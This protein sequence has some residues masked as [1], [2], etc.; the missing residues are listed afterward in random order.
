MKRALCVRFGLASLVLLSVALAGCS[1]VDVGAGGASA[2]P[3]ALCTGSGENPVS[4]ASCVTYSQDQRH[5]DNTRY[6]D[7]QPVSPSVQAQLDKF[8]APARIALEALAHTASSADVVG[9]FESAGWDRR[10]VQTEDSEGG[11][12]TFGADA[13]IGCLVGAVR[14]DGT[15]TVTAGGYINDGGCLAARGH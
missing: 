15:V 3:R 14:A 6:R 13:K 2:T 7:Q 8:V 12:V 9:A 10:S 5:S 1:K 4:N 11:G